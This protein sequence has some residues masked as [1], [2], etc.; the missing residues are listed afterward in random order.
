MKALIALL[1]SLALLP[2]GAAQ[3]N[4]VQCG[5]VITQNTTLDS[6]L[7]DCPGNGVVIGADNIT[8]DLAGHTIDGVPFQ[9]LD[10]V[11]V[12]A[13]DG[14]QVENGSVQQFNDGIALRNANDGR[15]HGVRAREVFSGV[16]LKYADRNQVD[17]NDATAYSAGI[18]VAD[19]SQANLIEHNLLLH[20]PNG[21]LLKPQDVNPTAPHD[22]TIV[23]NTISD[24]QYG[25]WVW[26][27]NSNS[28]E[29]NTIDSNSEYGVLVTFTSGFNTFDRNRLK[30]NEDGIS[31]LGQAENTIVTRNRISHSVE[32]GIE[33]ATIGYV[34]RGATIEGNVSTSNGDDGIDVDTADAVIA[35]NTANFNSDLGIEAVP[36]VT[37]GGG[38][39]ARG[40]G[41]PAQCVNVRCR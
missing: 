6:D 10:G 31:V 35:K 29:R 22:N 16:L 13:H 36:G 25:I 30:G 41:N 28:F 19:A 32:D 1:A 5:D 39:K 27:A 2:V 26:F 37:D 7:T 9:S 11:N 17:W 14:V 8:L 18:E 3:A 33:V 20:N 24:G 15:V 21:V 38:N 40:N 23:R 4:H 12:D 34:Q